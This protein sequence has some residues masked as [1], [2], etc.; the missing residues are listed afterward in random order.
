[1]KLEG[2]TALVTGST[3]GIG[4]AIA[5]ELARNGADVAVNGTKGDLAQQVSEE[6]RALSRDGLAVPCDVTISNNVR[7]MVRKTLD[8]FGKI[9]ILVCSAGI[10]GIALAVETTDQLWNDMMAVNTNAVFYCCREVARHMIEQRKGKIINIGSF[11]SK[12]GAEYYSHYTA[13]KFAVAGFSQAL[14][15]ELAPYNINVNVI[16][17]GQ[18][19]TDM[20]RGEVKYYMKKENKTEQEVIDS[21]LS[22]IA[23]RRLEKPED[24]A[25]LAL[26]LAS[27]DSDYITGQSINVDGGIFFID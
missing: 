21:M 14:A 6:I 9:D 11:L 27:P 2:K 19:D 17:P 12:I 5:L 3:R 18:V 20:L 1:M 16:C 25:K 23:L 15:K 7:D 8:H 13:S 10:T 24:V 22:I 4:K 26:F